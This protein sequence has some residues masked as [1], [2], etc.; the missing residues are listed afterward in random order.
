MIQEVRRMSP[1]EEL[2]AEAS[3]PI[4]AATSPPD[5]S[6]SVQSAFLPSYRSVLAF[7]HGFPQL[8]GL[9]RTLFGEGYRSP[10]HDFAKSVQ[11]TALESFRSAFGAA[12][13]S[14]LEDFAQSIQGTALH[15]FRSAFGAAYKSP[16]E[17]FAQSIQ[18]TALHSFRS[19]YMSPLQGFSKAY[20][21]FALQNFLKPALEPTKFSVASVS[22]SAVRP[23][24]ES[25]LNGRNSPV[26]SV[27]RTFANVSKL[28]WGR[29]FYTNIVDSPSIAL[30]MRSLFEQA[31]REQLKETS[32]DE[33]FAELARSL[34]EEGFAQK[35][36]DVLDEMTSDEELLT[37]VSAYWNLSVSLQNRQDRVALAVLTGFTLFLLSLG[38][39]LVNP[40]LVGALLTAG[41]IGVGGAKL[42]VRWSEKATQKI[43]QMNQGSA[44]KPSNRDYWQTRVVRRP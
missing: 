23:L 12:Y 16:L 22:D 1:L 20:P 10:L 14:P 24:V 40:V 33:E 29:N 6:Q 44:L 27:A 43:E 35:N 21:G 26:S 25:V 31:T 15:S 17:D 36:H 13:K 19:A 9:S 4:E 7:S 11:G 37:S 8:T 30:S 2:R 41:G 38:G 42:T 3:R 5:A 18:G 34:D 32:I 39:L 28:P